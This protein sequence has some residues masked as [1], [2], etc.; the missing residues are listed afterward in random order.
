[1]ENLVQSIKY[2]ERVFLAGTHDV[3]DDIDVEI[4]GLNQVRLG[5]GLVY[6]HLERLGSASKSEVH[7]LFM[8]L[9][10]AGAAADEVLQAAGLYAHHVADLSEVEAGL[11]ALDVVDFLDGLFGRVF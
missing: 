4:G 11:G 6:N 3:Q 10:D 9:F 7:M 2:L 5:P 1:M 8:R